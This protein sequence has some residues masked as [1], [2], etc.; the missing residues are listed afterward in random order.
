MTKPVTLDELKDALDE[1]APKYDL[2]SLR[3]PNASVE[4]VLKIIEALSAKAL[5]NRA[6]KSTPLGF[7]KVNDKV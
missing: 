3:F 4:E 5:Q 7:N 6:E 1:W 2:I